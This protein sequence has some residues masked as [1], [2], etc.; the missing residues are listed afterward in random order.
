VVNYSLLH[1]YYR[2]TVLGCFYNCVS[3]AECKSLPRTSP[4][5]CA[6]Y[7]YVCNNT[8]PRLLASFEASGNAMLYKSALYFTYQQFMTFWFKPDCL[9]VK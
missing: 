3:A 8:M 7:L 6:Q 9:R 4:R 5:H 1:G 2:S